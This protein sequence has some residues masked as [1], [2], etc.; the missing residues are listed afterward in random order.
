MTGRGW[1]EWVAWNGCPPPPP[2]APVLA[3]DID[4][5]LSPFSR[6]GGYRTIHLP[7]SV[8]GTYPS[9]QLRGDSPAL[10]H[11]GHRQ[12]LWGLHRHGVYLVW[13]TSWEDT[14][15]HYATAA[16]LPP[17]PHIRHHLANPTG[18]T[19]DRWKAIALA[20]VFPHHPLAWIDDNA[21]RYTHQPGTLRPGPCAVIAP[22]PDTGLTHQQRRCASGWLTQHMP[23]THSNQPTRMTNSRRGTP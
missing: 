21:W 8:I 13:A 1:R 6:P 16:G 9:A 17:M 14:A 5:V 7:S 2:G 4:G 10:A 12:W 18:L 3:L 20:Q 23:I 19:P 15:H 22:E 11:P